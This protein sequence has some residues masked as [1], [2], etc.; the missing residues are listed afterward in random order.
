MGEPWQ[1]G[2]PL[3]FTVY[4]KGSLMSKKEGKAL[5]PSDYFEQHEFE[6]EIPIDGLQHARLYVRVSV[7]GPLEQ[8]APMPSQNNGFAQPATTADAGPQKL[9]VSIIKATGLKHLNFTGDNLYCEACVKHA[10]KRVKANAVRTKTVKQSLDPLWNETFE[11]EPW[12]T[13]EPL[14]FTVYDKG[15]LMSKKEGK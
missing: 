14:E 11:V 1:T 7:G 13:G 2:E 9:K 12:Q 3:E 5:L 6:G 10:D 8:E 15:S 4:D